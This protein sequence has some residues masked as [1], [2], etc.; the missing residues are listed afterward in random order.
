[1]FLEIGLLLLAL[2]VIWL[3]TSFA[4]EAVE[5]LTGQSHWSKL[6][7]SLFFIGVVTSLPEIG[8]TANALLL[9]SPQVAL[10]SL[11]GSQIF[12]LFFV[13]PLLAIVGKGLHLELH[14]K[15][16]LLFFTLLLTALPLIALSN[17]QI[18][19]SETLLIIGAYIFFAFFFVKQQSM[20]ENV[21]NRL[22]L[23]R[24]TSPSIEV[25]KLLM[26]L[27]VITLA[28]HSVVR[29]LIEVAALLQTPRFLVSLVLLP[30]GTNLPELSMALQ[31]I[32]QKK[33]QVALSDFLGSLTFNAVLIA[34][35]SLILGGT[36]MS[37]QSIPL[38][39]LAF[40]IGILLFG[41]SSLTK[42]TLSTIEGVGLLLVYVAL[43]IAAVWQI[44]S[45]FS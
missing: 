3:A 45:S 44:M 36:L 30:V 5:N 23:R 28:T 20:L 34:L 26:A 11:I 25:I 29:G 8:I 27:G 39:I 14:L 13:I 21:A 17:Q 2:V 15:K 38:V 41:W 1:M 32:R 9:N 10:G 12:L 31:S 35:L 16:R 7:L 18:D 24:K 37:G 6:T 4:I 43:L 42:K 33:R 22:L 40:V 19:V